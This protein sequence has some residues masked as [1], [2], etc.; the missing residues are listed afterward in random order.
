MT[1]V[2]EAIDKKQADDRAKG[3]TADSPFAEIT[4]ADIDSLFS[5]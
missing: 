5:S 1:A 3:G 2:F 4:D